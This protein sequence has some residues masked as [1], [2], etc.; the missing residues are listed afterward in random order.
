[1]DLRFKVNMSH[2]ILTTPLKFNVSVMINEVPKPY[3][4]ANVPKLSQNFTISQ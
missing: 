4:F 3:R 1:M 2:S